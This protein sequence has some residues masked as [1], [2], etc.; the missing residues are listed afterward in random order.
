MRCP[1]CRSRRSLAGSMREWFQCCRGENTLHSGEAMSI[2]GFLLDWKDLNF[3]R[4]ALL[5]TSQPEVKSKT[6]SLTFS[7]KCL[8]CGIT[9]GGENNNLRSP[10]TWRLAVV[11]GELGSTC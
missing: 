2:F 1:S 8:A 10:L 5:L 7:P 9:L 3:C 6:S 11:T 4:C